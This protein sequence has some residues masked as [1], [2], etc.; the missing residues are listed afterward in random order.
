LTTVVRFGGAGVAVVLA[1]V[2]VVLV[3]ARLA[4]VPAVLVTARLAGVTG[5]LDAAGLAGVGLVG[6]AE[7]F[8]VAGAAAFAGRAVLVAAA[9]GVL[10]DRF[11]VRVADGPTAASV[12]AAPSARGDPARLA[13]I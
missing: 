2:P 11:V 10:V 6:L 8:F 1:A 4:G 7:V 9:A 13:Y 3:A 5:D 12:I